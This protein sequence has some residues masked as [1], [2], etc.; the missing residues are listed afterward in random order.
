MS[1]PT[2]QQIENILGEQTMKARGYGSWKA[3]DGEF[4]FT[5]IERKEGGTVNFKI[6]SG[7]PVKVFLNSETGELRMFPAK[8]FGYPEEEIK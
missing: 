4:A 1:K 7:L 6:G 5:S 3:V 2:I 8:M